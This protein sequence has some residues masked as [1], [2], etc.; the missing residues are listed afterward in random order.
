MSSVAVTDSEWD[1][2]SFLQSD[3]MFEFLSNV[4]N[5]FTCVDVDFMRRVVILLG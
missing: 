2:R 3:V 5:E 4:Q 1:G